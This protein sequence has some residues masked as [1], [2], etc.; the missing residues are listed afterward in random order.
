MA[1]PYQQ[2]QQD[3][4]Q[5]HHQQQ[6]NPYPPPQQHGHPHA[7]AAPP[8]SLSSAGDQ[9]AFAGGTYAITHRDTNAILTI[10]LQPG[11]TVRSAPGAMVHMAA[12]VQL[13]GKLKFSM[14]KLL[15]GGEMHEST[16]AGP[17]R[18]A[19]GPTLA[20]DIVTL[21]IEPA[22]RWKVGRDAF[23]ACTP[24]VRREHKS[25]G[26]GK[27]LFSGEDLFVYHVA[28]EGVMWLTSFGAVD[29]IDVS[30]G[31]G[32]RRRRDACKCHPP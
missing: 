15:A 28:G 27:A 25:Q 10:D 24:D 8:P 29:R 18:V 26:F 14:R 17:G 19:L 2:Q 6:H 1:Y 3:P 13:S 22:A 16:Y 20:G 23:L 4:Y 31:G 12:T 30:G 32:R 9:G 21:P 5:Q 11:A 7:A